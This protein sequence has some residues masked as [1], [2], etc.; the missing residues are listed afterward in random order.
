IAKQYFTA[1]SFEFLAD[2]FEQAA[3]KHKNFAQAYF[4]ECIC[5]QR[6]HEYDLAL[7]NADKAI[8]GIPN[9]HEAFV[10][11]GDIYMWIGK[12]DKSH[13]DYKRAS[14]IRP[15]YSHAHVMDGMAC[16]REGSFPRAETAFA[17]AIRK[18][19]KEAEIKLA[20]LR[21]KAKTH[22]DGDKREALFAFI[23]VLMEGDQ[24][25][26]GK[27]TQEV[28]KELE[29]RD[30]AWVSKAQSICGEF[31]QASYWAKELEK[32][33]TF[34]GWKDSERV[35]SDT[36]HYRV[37]SKINQNFNDY[38]GGQ[39]ESAY[40]LYRM[41]FKLQI[42]QK[43]Q[44]RVF[45]YPDMKSYYK[46]GAPV[47]SGGYANP[48]FKKLVWPI[49]PKDYRSNGFSLSS[50]PDADNLKDTLLVLFHEAFHQYL[51]KFLAVA[52]QV[53]NEGCADYFGP[54]KFN[55]RRVGKG[56]TG[57]LIVRVNSWRLNSIKQMIQQNVHLPL[58]PFWKETK[59]EMYNRNY[60][61]MNYAQAW[62]WV[63][64][65]FEKIPG[66]SWKEKPEAEKRGPR[67]HFDLLGKYYQALRKGR[68][69]NRAWDA[70]FGKLRG[71]KLA[72][73]EEEWKEFILKLK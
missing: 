51:N 17:E 42:P 14:E 33:K 6:I 1:D 57:D 36:E 4:Y 52:P 34:P 37:Y 67:K 69:L 60:S 70:S 55:I 32:E 10:E 50:T 2:L 58:E 9:F 27:A 64:F 16:L 40:K 63:F 13:T 7:K 26:M 18:G 23:E 61:G 46:D 25:K 30:R 15:D 44:V 20:D 22:L 48:Y 72:D 38:I 8:K 39:L 11:R 29:G 68:G 65:L 35:T 56:W 3:R 43:V 19:K 24:K 28:N 21:E 49:N 41:K 66:K 31:M 47:G 73:L 54:S 59:G 71:R 5:Q 12:T 53:F 62:A 45:L